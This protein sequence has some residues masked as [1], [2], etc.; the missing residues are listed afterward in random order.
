MNVV[1]MADVLQRLFR[2]SAVVWG[3]SALA[4]L[5][6]CCQQRQ[7]L[8]QQ[9]WPL[10]EHYA[11]N[12]I[13]AQG[14]VIDHSAQD[15]TTSEGQAYGMFFALVAND[16]LRFDKILSWTEV[17]LAQGDLTVHLPAWNW[18]KNPDGSWKTIDPNPASDGDLWMAY[19]LMEAG[20]LWNE[21]RYGKLGRIMAE[22]IAQVEVVN[23][24]G[25]GTTLLP[26]PYGF[27]PDAT[28]WLLNPSYMPPSVLT[29]LAAASPRGPWGAVRDSLKKILTEGSGGGFA[30]DWVLAGYLLKPGP[31]P[32]QLAAGNLTAPGIGSYDAIRVYLWLGMA[33]R[34]TPGLKALLGTMSGMTA[35]MAQHVTPPEIVD[36]TGKV[37]DP[38]A[39]P[40]FSAA[41]IPFL[42]AV[43]MKKEATIQNDRLTVTQDKAS[44]LYG[45]EKAYYDQNLALFGT[46]WLEQRIR[47]ERDGRL[48][49]KWR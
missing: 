2:R 23:V 28:T 11:Q 32:A 26:G 29:Y 38:N 34:D 13:D 15:R 45:R 5:L 49:V 1:R 16:R 7:C 40:G 19:T 20:R 14:R 9:S 41:L 33:D 22:R 42:S 12:A 46:G 24:P 48:K 25:L 10:W 27:H 35:Y 37:T 47:F 31:K 8:A 4:L 3:W 18:G 30:M 17:N 44:G 6:A 36:S 21:P 39:P 43:G